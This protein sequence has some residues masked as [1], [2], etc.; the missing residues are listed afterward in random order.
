MKQ[1]Q[2]TKP[3]IP[4]L[5]HQLTF[6][7]DIE[8]ST[9][10]LVSGYGAGKSYSFCMKAIYLAS[11]NIGFTGA[12]LEPTN[13]MC[14]DILIPQMNSILDQYKIPYEFRS[15]PLPEYTLKF[16]TGTTKILLRSAEN[17][18]RLVGL[19]LAFAGIDETDTLQTELA[20]SMYRVVQSRLRTGN[21]R[22]LFITSTPEGYGFLYQ[23]THTDKNKDSV[24]LIKA[25]TR[26]N[27]FLPE[28][29][30]DDLIKS[31]PP[32]L[33]QAYLEGE[34]VNL[35]SETV[36][37]NFD[38]KLNH[39]DKT[40]TD[41]DERIALHIG[42]DFNIGKCASII[43]VIDNGL[44]VVIDEILGTKRT[45]DTIEVIRRRYPNRQINIYPDASGKSEK[46]N[47]SQTD[48]TLLKQ[49]G[50]NVYYP[51]KNPPV[52]DRIGSVNAMLLN[53]EGN[54]RLKINTLMCKG[55]TEA[56]EQQT[57]DKNGQPD[58]MH[59]KDH[60]VDALGYFIHWAFPLQSR[61]T[62]RTY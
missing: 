9:L 50:F 40:L 25:R 16:K 45:E 59:D 22:Q 48:I 21:R 18:R 39:S 37:N 49:A 14:R 7:E 42:V 8:S 61:P 30:I 54:R 2:M 34:F 60:P 47:A 62:L 36:Y 3:K 55:L 17:H 6:V 24:R 26:D 46:T 31:Y 43:F 10:C 19:N 32:Q 15:S 51:T 38:R 33:I 1:H 53:G 28:S 44:P 13:T 58:K 5:P 20:W 27:P 11:L 23:L 12:L 35:N 29:Y 52:R 4:L 57:Y 41:Y 56:L